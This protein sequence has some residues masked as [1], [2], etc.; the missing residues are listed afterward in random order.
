MSSERAELLR[1]L[2]SLLVDLSGEMRGDL[3]IQGR[4]V[5]AVPTGAWLNGTPSRSLAR[6]ARGLKQA[7]FVA[8]MYTGLRV[9]VVEP[10]GD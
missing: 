1:D 7:V 5:V 6:G 4:E 2:R 8:D 3:Y 9:F 10:K